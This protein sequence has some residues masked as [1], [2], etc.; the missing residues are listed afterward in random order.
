[1]LPR[2]LLIFLYLERVKEQKSSNVYVTRC[3]QLPFLKGLR[4]SNDEPSHLKSS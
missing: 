3:F 2:T 1:M 4:R